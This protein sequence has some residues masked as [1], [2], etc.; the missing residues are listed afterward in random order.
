MHSLRPGI[1]VLLLTSTFW[2]AC[3]HKPAQQSSAGVHTIQPNEVAAVMEKEQA[4]LLD[5]RTPE[6]VAAGVIAGTSLFADIKSPDFEQKIAALDKNKAYIVY[7][8]SGARSSQAAQYMLSKG[9]TRI[10]NLEG[11]ILNWPA[12]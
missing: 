1:I 2:L 10:Y 9:F 12:P 8:R 3:N 4:V 7:C 6:E 5:V 11:G